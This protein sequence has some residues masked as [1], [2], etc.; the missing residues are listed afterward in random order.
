M[1]Q[2]ICFGDVILN[3]YI[4]GASLLAIVAVAFPK[5]PHR[6]QNDQTPF[7]NSTSFTGSRTD[8]PSKEQIPHSVRIADS[9]TPT[10]H[11]PS[12]KAVSNHT[13]HPR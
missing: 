13:E 9:A 8:F 1:P 2:A 12:S 7:T 6:T 3:V 10:H 11:K 5:L 4:D